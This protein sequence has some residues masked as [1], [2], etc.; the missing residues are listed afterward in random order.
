MEELTR[1]KNIIVFKDAEIKNLKNEIEKLKNII[2]FFPG[3][4]VI[5]DKYGLIEFI[6]KE[7]VEILHYS[8]EEELIGKNWFD[9][10]IP[11]NIRDSL[12]FVFNKIIEGHIEESKYYENL[13]ETKIKTLKLIGWRNSYIKDEKG[14]ISK[15]I[16]YGIEISKESFEKQ[17]IGD[18]IKIFDILPEAIHIIDREFK[19]LFFN[20]VFEKW[21]KI[22]GFTTDV[23]GKKLFDI[24]P[25]L[26]EKVKEEYEKV[27][28]TGD[29]LITKEKN[30]ISGKEI[31][32]ET[33][34]IPIFEKEKVINV[35]TFIR[36]IADTLK[37]YEDNIL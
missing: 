17:K 31:L 26:P 35:I 37:N 22:L 36:E 4:I 9:K 5:L 24:F 8:S 10:C 13:V 33:R 16:S 15:T 32:T 11:E 1:L 23:I 7:G 6:N 25:F 27:F 20:K 30:F 14:N 3:I 21:N 34:K 18:Y 19:I 28:N 2:S 29:I 12:K